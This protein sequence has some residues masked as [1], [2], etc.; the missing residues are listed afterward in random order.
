[1]CFFKNVFWKHF[2]LKMFF[3]KK[4]FWKTLQ[5]VSAFEKALSI[6]GP[7]QVPLTQTVSASNVFQKRLNKTLFRNMFF[8]N[9]CLIWKKTSLLKNL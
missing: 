1:M 5:E 2:F 4:R 9:V 6:Q 7:Q 3:F 8:K